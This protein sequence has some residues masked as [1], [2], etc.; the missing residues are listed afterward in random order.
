[1]GIVIT[2]AIVVSLVSWIYLGL[3]LYRDHLEERE[4]VTEEWRRRNAKP[5]AEDWRAIGKDMK[6]S[7]EDVSKGI[8]LLVGKVDE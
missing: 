2:A 7:I 1:M 8:E 6:K 5:T 4:R 3:M